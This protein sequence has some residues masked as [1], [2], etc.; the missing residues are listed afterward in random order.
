MTYEIIR[1]VPAPPPVK[2]IKLEVSIEELMLLRDAVG[3]Y[4]TSAA[5]PLYSQLWT[6]VQEAKK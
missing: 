5:Y 3:C 6:A 2:S 1:D 4:T